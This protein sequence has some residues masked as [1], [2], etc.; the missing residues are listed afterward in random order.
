MTANQAHKNLK[1]LAD[2]RF[3]LVGGGP[4]DERL[5]K[6][7]SARH[8]AAF[9]S[10]G[11]TET[12]TQVALRPVLHDSGRVYRALAG[13]RFSTDELSRLVVHSDLAL[14]NPLVTDDVVETR[15]PESFVWK[16]RYS[17]VILS[18]GLKI[19]PETLES[20]LSERIAG[21][22]FLGGAIDETLGMKS[23]F[24]EKGPIPKPDWGIFA[25]L[26]RLCVSKGIFCPS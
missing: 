13:V 23:V 19:Q 11:M 9:C 17:N 25:G 16:G 6:K 22:F 8:E 15:S 21:S 4:L 14:R 24:F 18:G 2:H 1:R 12:Y 7:I 3:L 20:L 5:E 26:F 10:F